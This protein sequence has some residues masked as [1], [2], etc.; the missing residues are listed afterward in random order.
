[1][2]FYKSALFYSYFNT[3]YSIMSLPKWIAAV[4]GIGEVVNKNYLVVLAGAVVFFALCLLA[5]WAYIK[6]G[7]LE[8]M[9]EVG[10]KHNLLAKE[11]RNS[12]LFKEDKHKKNKVE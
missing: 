5:G 12:K 11:L 1:M 3:G 2:R 8:A 10:N 4:F 7:F 9:Q 6:S